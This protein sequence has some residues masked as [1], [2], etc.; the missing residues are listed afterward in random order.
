[1]K[2]KKIIC[3]ILILL[4]AAIII[5]GIITAAYPAITT[6]LSTEDC[7]KYLEVLDEQIAINA[8]KIQSSAGNDTGNENVRKRKLTSKD[9]YKGASK[10]VQQILKRQ[11]LIGIISIKKLHIRFPIAEGTTR[12]NI[13]SSIGRLKQSSKIEQRGGNCVLAGHRGGIYG[14]FFKNIHK[15][16]RGDEVKVTTL[17]GTV[18]TYT[19]CSSKVIKP[20]QVKEACRIF[21]NDTVLTLLSCTDNGKKR[22][23]VRCR[24][25]SVKSLVDTK[26]VQ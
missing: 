26:E 15:L 21:P 11:H 25:E 19:A 10:D 24:L 1:M 8:K 9:L 2:T 18:Y 20:T 7:N 5:G 23:L 12:D 4:G 6:Y 22:L 16:K 3:I 13:R 17:D 14:E